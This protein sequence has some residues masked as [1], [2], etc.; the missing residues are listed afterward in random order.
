M[1]S[2]V[3]SVL[4]RFR[5]QGATELD[6]LTFSLN[7]QPLPQEPACLRRINEMYRMT[8]PRCKSSAPLG[9]SG[10]EPRARTDEV[11]RLACVCWVALLSVRTDR[12]NNSYWFCFEL[13]HFAE[14]WPVPGSNSISVE[15]EH[16]D[17]ALAASVLLTV[18][19]V[20][21]DVQYLPGRA[22]HRGQDPA[23]GP[24]ILADS[25]PKL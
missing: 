9:S 13:L 20:E 24:S 17:G 3:H 25:R 10:Q 12:V 14:H 11:W 8:A 22:W 6:V 7:G 16:R 5:V 19:D 4:L 1:F 2:Q 18:R 21:L 15:C 23:L